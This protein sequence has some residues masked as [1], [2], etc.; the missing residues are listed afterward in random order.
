MK[1]ANE[2][3]WSWQQAQ[4]GAVMRMVYFRC[5]SA[6]AQASQILVPQAIKSSRWALLGQRRPLAI[7]CLLPAAG[8]RQKSQIEYLDR[9]AGGADVPWHLIGSARIAT[10]AGGFNTPAHRE[11]TRSSNHPFVHQSLIRGSRL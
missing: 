2:D 8:E 11:R 9:L 1:G 5:T 10:L 3:K 4:A 6:Q 7:Y